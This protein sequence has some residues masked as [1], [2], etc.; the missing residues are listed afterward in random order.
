[1]ALF[2]LLIV[3]TLML[4]GMRFK[5]SLGNAFM[6]GA[7]ALGFLFGQA[8]PAI[9]ISAINALADPKTLALS[10]VVVLIL[11]LSHSM[12]TSGQM[13]RLLD[14]F[15]GLIRHEGLNMVIFPALI[16][17]LPMPGGA[18][19]SAPMVKNIG[20][21]YRLEGSQLS[22][23]NYWFRHLWEY[24]WPL[25]PGVL[26][27]TTLAALDLWQFIF[28]LFPLTLAAFTIG[29]LPLRGMMRQCNRKAS[30]PSVSSTP[31]PFL[32]ELAPI[33]IV[34]FPGLIIGSLLTPVFERWGLNIAKETG[35]IVA[36]LI[37]VAW[38][39][40]VNRFDFSSRLEIIRSRAVVNIFYMVTAILIFKGG[41]E[42]CNAV[43]QISQAFLTWQIPL[44]PIAMLLP[45]MVGIVAGITI[46][47]VGTTFPILISLIHTMGETHLMLPYMMLALTTGFAGVLLSPLHLCLLL[48]NEYF[49]TSLLPVYRHLVVPCT[50]LVGC[51]I[52]YFWIISLLPVL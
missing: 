3:F 10:V 49:H 36:L 27:T 31:G 23:V 1:M 41:L 15:R 2:K 13:T 44:F 16:G 30:N 17:L 11:I 45:F 25:Y 35:L 21:Q 24:C 18:I 47:F 34:I 12:E 29:Y 5:I 48:S 51:G 33:L 46:A 52:A 42:D 8:P 32:K 39:W 28:S 43:Q 7:I 6:L 9:L 14:G 37:S 20:S 19:F 50:L 26:L 22:Y 40:R 4:M 38:T